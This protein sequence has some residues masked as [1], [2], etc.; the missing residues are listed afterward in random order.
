MDRIP[1]PTL[2]VRRSRSDACF[3]VWGV[4]WLRV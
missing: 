1:T 2:A 4:G 3:E